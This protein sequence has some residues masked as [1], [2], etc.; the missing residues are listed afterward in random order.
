MP[1]GKSAKGGGF[2][3]GSGPGMGMGAGGGEAFDRGAFRANDPNAAHA[4]DTA[5]ELARR[6]GTGSVGNA[7]TAGAQ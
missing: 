6:I 4:K 5:A 1:K 2:G 7:A 3:G